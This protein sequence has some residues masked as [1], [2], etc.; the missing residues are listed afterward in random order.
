MATIAGARRHRADD[1]RVAPEVL[2]AGV[3][4]VEK[5]QLSRSALRWTRTASDEYQQFRQR[6]MTASCV[7]VIDDARIA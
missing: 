3:P 2:C 4:A 6:Y 5:N 1:A 7:H